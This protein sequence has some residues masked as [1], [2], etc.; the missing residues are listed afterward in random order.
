[1]QS[2]S[3]SGRETAQQQKNYKPRETGDLMADEVLEAV[4]R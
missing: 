1:M 2:R 4:K 3:I